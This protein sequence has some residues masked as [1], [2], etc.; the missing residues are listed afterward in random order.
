[1]DTIQLVATSQ[2][3]WP[4]SPVTPQKQQQQTPLMPINAANQCID[5]ECNGKRAQFL[6]G[7]KKVLYNHKEG[8]EVV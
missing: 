6:V 1:M 2:A 5:I 8:L 4:I 7:T 3:F